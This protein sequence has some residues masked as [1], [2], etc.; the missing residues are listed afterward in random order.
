MKSK[1]GMLAPASNPSNWETEQEDKEVEGQYGLSNEI[2][3]QKIKDKNK[4]KRMER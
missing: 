3:F 4:A 2:V 1:A